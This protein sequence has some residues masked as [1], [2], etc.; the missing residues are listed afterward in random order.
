[1]AETSQYSQI[2]TKLERR[3]SRIPLK[4]N[5]ERSGRLRNTPKRPCARR[6]Q[7]EKEQVVKIGSF[8]A[9]APHLQP[10]TRNTPA[11]NLIFKGHLLTKLMSISQPNIHSHSKG[12]YSCVQQDP[13]D[14]KYRDT[15][16]SRS[17]DKTQQKYLLFNEKETMR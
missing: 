1:M 13:V 17:M 4:P 9:A 2:S 6:K 12:K 11:L 8:T 16:N 7:I 5:R 10:P 14:L 3:Q 15:T